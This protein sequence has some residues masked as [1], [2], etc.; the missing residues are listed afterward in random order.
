[1]LNTFF[2]LS[3]VFQSWYYLAEKKIVLIIIGS[4]ISFI[5]GYLS[6]KGKKDIFIDRAIEL[7]KL[8]ID[9]KRINYNKRRCSV[10]Y[11]SNL[12]FR[13]EIGHHSYGFI[14]N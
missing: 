5:T 12:H 9:K 1:M 14:I 13:I 8:S 2:N 4:L 6:T 10:S 7:E 3:V 11:K